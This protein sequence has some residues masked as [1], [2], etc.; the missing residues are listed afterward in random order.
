[1]YPARECLPFFAGLLP[2]GDL[3][4]RISD[5][6]HISESSTLKLLE[7]LGG[8]CAG[9]ISLSIEDSG[10]FAS[11]A[12][13]QIRP[14]D[15]YRRLE[16]SEIAAMI[17]RMAERPLL[18]GDRE[19]RL[20]L[21]GAQQKI[22]LAR[23]ADSWHL[24][25]RGAPSTHILKPSRDP[26]PDLAAN[27]FLCMR[28]ARAAGLPVPAT[29]LRRFEGIPVFIIERYDR[30]ITERPGT[31]TPGEIVE[32]IHQEDA[33]QA[34][35]IMPDRKYQN[36][37]GP[38]FADIAA[39]IGRCS[40]AP[41]LDIRVLLQTAVFNFLIGNCDA[42]G[43]NF[44]FLY[45]RTGADTK[46]TIGLAPLYDLVSTTAYSGLSTKLSMSI[47]GEYR[48]ERIRLEHFLRLGAA[49]GVSDK[50]MKGLLR[51]MLVQMPAALEK[52][53]S[54][55]ELKEYAALTERIRQ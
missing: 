31:E 1:E 15:G 34:K 44:S 43:K 7:A 40:A 11:F 29:E 24:P 30:Q 6:L 39:L 27:E 10:D 20:S 38:G 18:T 47:G 3:K 9:T 25:L 46:R 37:G 32:R 41:I 45:Q 28:T 36:D 42:H 21:A 12:E 55:D 53:A 17:D 8:E 19:L 14:Q 23:F 4:R 26:W 22:S 50:Y 16:T 2:D 13:E 54:L 52:A 48:I 5:Y 35:G 49:S 33:C 51:T